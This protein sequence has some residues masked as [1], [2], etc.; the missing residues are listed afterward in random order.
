MT[1][2]AQPHSVNF[3]SE[4]IDFCLVRRDDDKFRV[5][6]HPDLTVVV[7][8]PKGK[9]LD[10]VLARVKSKARWISRQVRYFEQFLPRMP[11]K[12]Y[13]SGETFHY[14]GRQYRLKV[15]RSGRME[16]KLLAPFLVVSVLEQHGNSAVKSLVQE[17]YAKHSRS[18]FERRLDICLESAVRNRIGR[19]TLRI[20][21]MRGRWGSCNGSGAILLNTEL[22]RAPT[23]CIDYVVTHELCHLRHP[24]HGP[25]F[26]QLLSRLMPDW[27]QRKERLERVALN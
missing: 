11:E 24:H 23:Y 4:R 17:W 5:V 13:L 8:A 27:R 26:Y 10:Q 9:A 12:R 20:R 1:R 25:K 22:A 16:V 6:V 15:A 7:E 21:R 2:T 19:P 3:G 18:I 14:L